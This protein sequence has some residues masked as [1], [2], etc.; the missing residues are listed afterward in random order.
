ML[1]L[2]VNQ[3]DCVMAWSIMSLHGSGEL[4]RVGIVLDGRVAANG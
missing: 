3:Y 4:R 1:L 2:F